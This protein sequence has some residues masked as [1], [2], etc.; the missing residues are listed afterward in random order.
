ML[1]IIIYQG[2]ASQNHSKIIRYTHE[3]GYCQKKPQKITIVG[4][5][6]EK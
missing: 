4:Q 6:M 1:T 2:N 3:D 5:D